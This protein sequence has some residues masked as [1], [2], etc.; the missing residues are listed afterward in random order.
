MQTSLG[1]LETAIVLGAVAVGGIV[2]WSAYRKLSG[3]LANPAALGAGAVNAA[4]SAVKT[5]GDVVVGG[6]SIGVGNALGVPETNSEKCRKAMRDNNIVDVLAYCPAATAG[7]AV[8]GIK[9]E[10]GNPPGY[11]GVSAT[12]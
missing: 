6:G 10:N 5:A 12:F 7:R 4:A 11:H 3:A 1:E 2:V 9:D 8:F